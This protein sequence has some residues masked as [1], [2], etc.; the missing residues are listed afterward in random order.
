MFYPQCLDLLSQG[1]SFAGFVDSS[2]NGGG[3]GHGDKS[4]LQCGHSNGFGSSD[5]CRSDGSSDKGGTRQRCRETNGRGLDG[6]GGDDNDKPVRANGDAA[7]GQ[8][9]AQPFDSA[10]HPLL[11]GIITHAQRETHGAEILVLKKPQQHRLPVGVVQFAHGLVKDGTDALP[12]RGCLGSGI[13]LFHNLSF[14]YLAAAL[15]AQQ[16]QPGVTCGAIKPTREGSLCGQ[17]GG[18]RPRFAGEVGKDAL[19][20]F[21]RQ[22]GRAHL[23]PRSRINQVGVPGDD[24][25]EGRFR[26]LPGVFPK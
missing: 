26:L 13:K 20:D 24:F 3:E 15:I 18:Q 10:A 7:F 14:V 4:F 2:T 25:A 11:R 1:R 9:F 17:R 5:G 12:I 19:G 23:P 6:M 21:A 22:L 16:T 8:D